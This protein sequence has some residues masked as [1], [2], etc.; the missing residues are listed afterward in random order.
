[1]HHSPS[2]T[3]I[4][5]LRNLAERHNYRY[6]LHFQTEILSKPLTSKKT[7]TAASTPFK[8]T[9]TAI[10]KTPFR[11]ELL[12]ALQDPSHAQLVSSMQKTMHNPINSD[13]LVKPVFYCPK[14]PKY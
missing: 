7:I 14:A 12:P 4:A 8:N 2:V 1:M 9:K 13:Q 5:A 6:V 10:G 3:S 11:R